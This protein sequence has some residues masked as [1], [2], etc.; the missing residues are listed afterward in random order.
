LPQPAPTPFFPHLLVLT[1]V[2]VRCH[3]IKD[4]SVPMFPDCPSFKN[5]DR[6][7]PFLD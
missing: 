6:I 4:T 7:E 1:Y 5:D 2:Q 3:S